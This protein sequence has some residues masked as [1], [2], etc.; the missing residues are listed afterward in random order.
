MKRPNGSIGSSMTFQS[1][2]ELTAMKTALELV[3]NIKA[4]KITIATESLSSLRSIKSRH[5]N[6]NTNLLNNIFSGIAGL[7]PNI[8]I[9]WIPNHIGI[10]GNEAADKLASKTDMPET[11]TE[12][13]T[14]RAET[15]RD[16][17]YVVQGRT[18]QIR[19]YIQKTR[20]LHIKIMH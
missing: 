20:N 2:A 5:S 10:H 14:S 17:E 8:N 9:L 4:N 11:K 1:S 3:K 15:G 12:T 7:K 6:T 19:T 13:E 18:D 16:Q